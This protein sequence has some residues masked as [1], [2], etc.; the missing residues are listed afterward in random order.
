VALSSPSLH[1]DQSAFEQFAERF[2]VRDFPKLAAALFRI[3]DALINFDVTRVAERRY[4]VVRRLVADT[5]AVALLVA[6]RADNSPV[7]CAT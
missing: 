1:L 6:V 7:L 4:P 2:P 3:F 5:L